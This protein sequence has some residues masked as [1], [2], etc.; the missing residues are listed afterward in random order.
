LTRVV[1]FMDIARSVSRYDVMVMLS[2]A[3]LAAA[4]LVWLSRQGPAWRW[5]GPVAA[6][7]ILF[8]FL[9]TPYPISAPDDHPW[10]SLLAQDPRP[11]A[12]L[13]LPMSFDRPGYLLQQIT[14]GKPL[15][16][17]YISR[18]DPRTLVERAPVL[19][20]FR[21]L[22]SGILRL[23]MAAQGQ[24]VLEDLGVRWVVVDRYQMP[25]GTERSTTD[26]LVDQI[27]T[28]RDPVYG[29]ER[30][31]VYEVASSGARSPYVLLESGWGALERSSG[32]RSFTGAASLVLRAPE[33]GSVVL[34]VGAMPGSARL[35]LPLVGEGPGGGSIYRLPL[36]LVPGDTVIE[37]RAAGG[38]R[39][40]ILGISLEASG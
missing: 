34:S 13:N 12:V 17:A 3:I 9:P 15:A 23:D 24:Q 19:Q 30:L 18:D 14:H 1:P 27:F 2:L 7:V 11:G 31:S 28:G 16:A 25:S 33:G 26:A 40:Q 38:G 21:N 36:E 6:A 10:Y 29:D 39:A 8:E 4:G 37:L 35:D 20:H 5:A 32:A 22:G